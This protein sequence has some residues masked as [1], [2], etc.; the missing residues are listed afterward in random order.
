MAAVIPAEW[1]GGKAVVFCATLLDG[2]MVMADD[3]VTVLCCMVVLPLLLADDVATVLASTASMSSTSAEFLVFLLFFGGGELDTVS[4][5]LLGLPGLLPIFSHDF[6]ALFYLKLLIF[7]LI[8]RSTQIFMLNL[9]TPSQK[10]K[11]TARKT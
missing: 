10:V 1:F 9:S 3:V 11:D 5:L 6:W 4:F 7:V 8:F 2:I